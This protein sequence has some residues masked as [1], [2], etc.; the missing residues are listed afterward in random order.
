M[1]TVVT[2][3]D[4]RALDANPDLIA[5]GAQAEEERRRRHG[6]RATFVRVAHARPGDPMPPRAPREAG[7]IRIGGRASLE[8]AVNAV[9]AWTA[10]ADGIPVTGFDVYG[11]QEMAAQAG[12]SL[13]DVAMRLRKAGLVHLSELRLA[14]LDAHVDDLTAAFHELAEGGLAVARFTVER[15]EVS[16]RVASLERIESFARQLGHAAPRAFAPLPQVTAE[17]DP[18]STG[19]DDVKL[20]ALAR[21]IVQSVSSIQIDWQRHGPKLAQVALLFGA[22]DLDNVEAESANP[23]LLGPRRVPLEEVRRNIRAASLDPVERTGAFHVLAR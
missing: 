3:A 9:A 11:I 7:E 17:D 8:E 16:D 13:R 10:L 4:V 15:S 22:D 1:D 18:P 19:Y 5:I 12:L 23:N 14:R 21:L 20:V 2:T 6:N